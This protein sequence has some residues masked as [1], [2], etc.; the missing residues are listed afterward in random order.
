M[1]ESYWLFCFFFL[2]ET[3][4]FFPPPQ[5]VFSSNSL[6]TPDGRELMAESEKRNHPCTFLALHYSEVAEPV[7]AI[8]ILALSYL[9]FIFIYTL[10]GKGWRISAIK[11]QTVHCFSP[12]PLSIILHPS[13]DLQQTVGRKQPC[14]T[15]INSPNLMKLRWLTE[16]Y[17]LPLAAFPPPPP[18]SASYFILSASPPHSTSLAHFLNN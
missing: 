2:S 5:P 9:R 3:H 8:G 7:T 11:S 17:S 1:P 6:Q 18:A 14:K 13:T 4:L 16:K 15:S 10:C 12:P